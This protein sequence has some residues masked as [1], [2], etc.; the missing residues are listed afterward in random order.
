MSTR[1]LTPYEQ[2]L[3]RRTGGDPWQIQADIAQYGHQPVEQIIGQA[4]FDGKLFKISAQTLIPRV[5]TEYLLDLIEQFFVKEKKLE[6]WSR[7]QPFRMIDIGTGCGAI[8]IALAQR[9]RRRWPELKLELWLT[10]IS[11][12]ALTIAKQNVATFFDESQSESLYCQVVTSDL[13][14][15]IPPTKFDLVIA[16]LPYIPEQRIA[17]LAS[18]VKDFEPHVALSG[19]NSGLVLAQ[20]LLHQLPHYLHAHSSVWFELD[21][22]HSIDELTSDIDWSDFKATP[23]LT[24]HHDQYRQPRFIQIEFDS[25]S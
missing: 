13:M 12:P 19:G 22:T 21:H 16:N 24:H 5:E 8:G 25:A 2:N 4:E 9:W 6:S 20:R 7:P 11:E 14:K 17:H 18:S 1:V 3:I 15:S 23:K 10:D